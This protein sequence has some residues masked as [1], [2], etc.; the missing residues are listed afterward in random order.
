LLNGEV[1][2]NEGLPHLVRDLQ[3]VQPNFFFG[4][5]RVWEQL[6]QFITA[7]FDSQAGIDAALASDRPGTQDKVLNLL[8][9]TEVDYCLTAAAPTPPS[10]IEWFETLGLVLMEGFGQT[11]AMGLMGNTAEDRRVGS[12]GKAIGPV[13]IRLSEQDELQVRGPGLATGYYKMPEKTAETFV[14]GWVHTGDKAR[15][16]DDGY[17]YITGRVKDYFKTIQGKFVA[18]TPIEN[19]FAHNEHTEQQCLLGRGYSKTVMV[20][21]LSVSA[22]QGNIDAIEA[23]LRALIESINKKVDHHARLGAL[24]ISNDPWTIENEILTPTMKIRREKIEER[25]GETAMALAHRSA[26]EGVLLVQ[27]WEK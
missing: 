5:P 24:I 1:T 21:V 11:E 26:V 2:F 15:I 20:C 8:G 25:F 17:I 23:D 19:M 10:L 16:D 9:L 4:P 22:Q 3:S 7:Q 27:H 12:I 18:P 6:Q 13:D 14:D